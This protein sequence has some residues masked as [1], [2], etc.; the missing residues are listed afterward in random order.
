MPHACRTAEH[1]RQPR[2]RP[3]RSRCPASTSAASV[4]SN[5]TTRVG[6]VFVARFSTR[7]SSPRRALTR[8][9]ACLGGI[10]A[11]H[12][13]ARRSLRRSPVCTS[14]S[15]SAARFQLPD[16]HA[17]SGDRR[18]SVAAGTEFGGA[19]L[20]PLPSLSKRAGPGC[21][22]AIPTA[23]PA[24]TRTVGRRD[25]LELHSGQAYQLRVDHA[26]GLGHGR[27]RPLPRPRREPLLDQVA[28]RLARRRHFSPTVP[29]SGAG[30]A[31][32]RRAVSAS[33]V[34]DR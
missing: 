21:S 16:V 26:T 14:N 1:Q 3:H 27:R 17:M 30:R 9:G 5:T 24:P 29:R 33:D 20:A 10:E 25:P 11:G 7:P 32:P 4:D 8:R 13:R 23:R 22:A 19:L 15:R 6:P 12:R 34:R 31:P 18:T 28:E 2:H